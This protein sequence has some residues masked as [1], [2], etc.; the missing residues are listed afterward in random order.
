MK[1]VI[2]IVFFAALGTMRFLWAL[3]VAKENKA[4][5]LSAAQ[6]KEVALKLYEAPA[7]CDPRHRR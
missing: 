6:M 3:I 1:R 4:P 7:L 5:E 2:P